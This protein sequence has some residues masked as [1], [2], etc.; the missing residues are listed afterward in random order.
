MEDTS[1]RKMFEDL[2]YKFSG[3]DK[4]FLYVKE[5]DDGV[6]DIDFFP[7]EEVSYDSGRSSHELNTQEIEA[8]CKQLE[9]LGMFKGS[10]LTISFNG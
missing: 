5:F 4:F 6:A 1:A 2:G 8:I 7:C 9:E 3:D 10:S